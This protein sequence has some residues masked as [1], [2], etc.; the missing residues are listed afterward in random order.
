MREKYIVK[1]HQDSI[2]FG[3]WF[4]QRNNKIKVAGTPGSRKYIEEMNHEYFM[5]LLQ[6]CSWVGRVRMEMKV[7]DKSIWEN[8]CKQLNESIELIRVR[9][10][11]RMIG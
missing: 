5:G 4:D 7:R 2:P 6:D 1:I 3:I 10:F 11:R 8:F 9:S